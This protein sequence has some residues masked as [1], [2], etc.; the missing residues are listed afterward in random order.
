MLITLLLLEGRSQ[1][2]ERQIEQARL[3]FPGSVDVE[4]AEGLALAFRG[5]RPGVESHLERLKSMDLL[6][7]S[8]REFQEKFL[9]LLSRISETVL[10]FDV[11]SNTNS[12]SDPIDDV[13][14]LRQLFANSSE[15][16][17]LMREA[18]GPGMGIGI[19][20]TP[21]E[22]IDKLLS[23]AP[24]RIPAANGALTL[25]G[26]PGLMNNLT[27][28]VERLSP[29]PGDAFFARLRAYVCLVSP[30]FQGAAM[31]FD[32]ALESPCIF[33]RLK[34]RLLYEA[35]MCHMGIYLG[36]GRTD[37]PELNKAGELALRWVKETDQLDPVTVQRIQNILNLSGQY[38][39]ALQ[40]IDRYRKSIPPSSP[41]AFA[42][43]EL[44]IKFAARRF[45][46]VIEL[47]DRLLASESGA[48]GEL[49]VH[50]RQKRDEAI[51]KL[52][53]LVMPQ[54]KTD[55]TP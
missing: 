40:L 46:E 20:E 38:D 42:G 8:D 17:R 33:P 37:Q 53:E 6:A 2:L 32:K 31:E 24:A 30:D 29:V 7:V 45:L 49:V 4:L 23:D 50:A 11:A 14:E 55:E 44:N 51:S 34:P 36:T 43:E 16:S 19:P 1:E 47:A 48:S 3:L 21:A 27:V 25:F 9:L 39:A 54:D 10:S 5:D 28:D 35:A 13:I 41:A 15:L 22:P 12:L 18:F 52:R 26:Q